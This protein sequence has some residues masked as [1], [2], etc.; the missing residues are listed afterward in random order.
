MSSKTQLT[1]VRPKS[2]KVVKPKPKI[3]MK[4]RSEHYVQHDAI[5][6]DPEHYLQRRLASRFPSLTPEREIIARTILDPA[7]LTSA[8][9]TLL[10]SDNFGAKAAVRVQVQETVITVPAGALVSVQSLPFFEIPYGIRA[11]DGNA[12]TGVPNK[13]AMTAVN[14]PGYWL[15][16]NCVYAYRTTAKSLT[17]KN[18]SAVQNQGG[19][20][21]TARF[22]PMNSIYNASPAGT[23]LS[24]ATANQTTVINCKVVSG[25]PGNQAE[26]STVP[27]SASFSGVDGCYLVNKVYNDDWIYRTDF[28][29]TG[30][31]VDIVPST[32]D[33]NGQIMFTD[34]SAAEGSAA[35][36]IKYSNATSG[37]VEG[38]V[39]LASSQDY[40]DCTVAVITAPGNDQTYLIRCVMV[41]E[42]IPRVGTV[43]FQYEL[44]SRSDDVNFML[45]VRR[46]ANH[47]LGMYPSSYNDWSKVFTKFKDWLGK[48][49]GFYK[50]NSSILKPALSLIPGV[51]TALS[52]ADNF[53]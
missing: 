30:S 51:G 17:I 20:I 2:Q 4:K 28:T 23:A 41:T 43:A 39:C 29:K 45:A 13:M 25:L 48:A 40:T 9:A 37:Y 12:M 42:F 19:T 52:I 24:G 14:N 8:D 32:T 6:P 7:H 33:A 36:V 3:L 27:E 22:S 18:V 53:I 15:Q 34:S 5:S 47:E 31:Q 16:K 38:S 35:N 49:A 44:D 26:S 21:S 10:P 46:F 11:A 1:I 50:N